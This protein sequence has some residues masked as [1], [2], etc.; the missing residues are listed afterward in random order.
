[1]PSSGNELMAIDRIL[2]ITS[3]RIGDAVLSTGVLDYLIKTHPE[4]KF[5]VACGEIATPL[6]DSIPQ[7]ERIIPLIKGRRARHWRELWRQ[8]VGVRWSLVADLR[9]SL[10]SWTVRTRKRVVYRPNDKP[11]HRVRQLAAAFKADPAPSPRLWL[12]EQRRSAA[13][14]IIPPGGKVVAIGPTANWKGKQWASER[15]I[16]LLER[17]T[18]PQGLYPGARIAV[19]GG[20]NERTAAEPI[21]A[22]IPLERRLDLVGTIDIGVA[23]ACLARCDLYIG[24]DSGLMHLA[25]AAGI[26]T[27]GLFGPSRE[28]H[29]GPWGTNTAAVRTR[30]DFQ[31]FLDSRCFSNPSAQGLLDSI[32]VEQVVGAVD[33]LL[34]RNSNSR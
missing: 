5:T 8:T 11:V 23:G 22:S 31:S 25:A 30:E 24:N 34:S 4:A 13:E 17:L 33:L 6:F 27:I 12:S 15:F 32:S 19:F 20:P 9:N 21:L 26:P 1:M 14:G 3:N 10:F 29:Y 16:S 18:G 2:F 28:E 7:V